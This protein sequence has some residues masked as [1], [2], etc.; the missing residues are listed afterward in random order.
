M[1][2]FFLLS[3]FFP[4]SNFES[5]HHKSSE[6]FPDSLSRLHILLSSCFA[7]CHL[8]SPN[9]PPPSFATRLRKVAWRPDYLWRETVQVLMD[10]TS[11]F[12][13]QRMFHCPLFSSQYRV[14][15]SLVY[16]QQLGMSGCEVCSQ[17]CPGR[18]RDWE[19]LPVHSALGQGWG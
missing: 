12:R 11:L 16:W 6:E 1:P 4:L 5:F 2:I 7:L 9:L 14:I 19:F 18:N 17:N 15:K 10:I 13:S 8:Y 3:K